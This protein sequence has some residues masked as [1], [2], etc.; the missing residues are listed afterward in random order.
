VLDAI[1]QGFANPLDGM[2]GVLL[3]LFLAILLAVIA[4]VFAIKRQEE[5]RENLDDPKLL[6]DELASA[7]ELSSSEIAAI[8]KVAA[9]CPLERIDF[10]FAQPDSW[11]EI[12]TKD[13]VANRVWE[14]L[15]STPLVEPN[16]PLKPATGTET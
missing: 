10:I 14:K 11:K 6:F 12:A 9:A 1:R 2:L 8:K 3:L 5:S 13:P 16:C 7:H 15:F 4:F